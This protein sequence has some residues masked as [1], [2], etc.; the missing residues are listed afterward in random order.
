[1]LLKV[2]TKHEPRLRTMREE[3]RAA[4]TMV[5]QTRRERK[6]DI[7]AS[8]ESRNYSANGEFR[9]AEVVLRMGLPWFN[10][11]KYR[12]AVQRDEAKAR[13]AEMDAAD[14]EA[15]LQEE[16]HG[17]TVKINAARREALAYRDDILPRS[18]QTVA[19]AQGAWESG[20]G[21]FRDVLDARR[22]RVE[23]QLMY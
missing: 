20:R 8:L 11:D 23:G 19:S 2:A 1:A 16:I 7:T 17:L 12:S 5:E 13:A 6:P 15:S 3:A 4:Q 21:M 22:M 10:R 9:Q 18:E 14:F